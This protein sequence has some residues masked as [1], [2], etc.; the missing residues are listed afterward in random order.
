MPFDRLRAGCCEL[1]GSARAAVVG[2]ALAVALLALA[3]GSWGTAHG[4]TAGG[5]ATPPPAPTPVSTTVPTTGGTVNAP[6]QRIA[7]QFPAGVTTAPIVVALFPVVPPTDAPVPQQ[8]L[9]QQVLQSL[10]IPLPQTTSGAP[11]L[12]AQIF[13]L[14]AAT[15][16]TGRAVTFDE[17]VTIYVDVTAETRALAGGDLSNVTLQ[18]FDEA[19]RRWTPVPCT[20]TT[21]GLDC[22]VTHFSLWAVVVRNVLASGALAPPAPARSLP[23]PAPSGQGPLAGSLGTVHASRT[24]P[25]VLAA[26]AVALV[27]ALAFVDMPWLRARP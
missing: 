2:A 24:V 27:G 20:A 21:I 19:A 26:L 12:V 17:P 5:A 6:D 18:F 10:A 13:R 4:Q 23:G 15:A 1:P 3:P 8:A 25:A 9:V 14:D 11:A 22:R 16:A 7:V